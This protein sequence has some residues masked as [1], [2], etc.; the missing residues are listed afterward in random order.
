[1]QDQD[2]IPPGLC[3][4]GCGQ[5]TLLTKRAYS[6]PFPYRKGEPYRYVY[7][8]GRKNHRPEY[9]V[10]PNGC[11]WWLKALSGG[12]GQGWD[13]EQS[14]GAHRL[15]YKRLRGPIPQGMTLDHLCHTRDLSCPGGESCL[16]RRCVNP[17]HLEVVPLATNLLRGRTVVA[18]N[19][20]KTAC[21][22]GHPFT[23]ETTSISTGGRR[24]C[25]TCKQAQAKARTVAQRRNHPLPPRPV[26]THCRRKHP[27]DGANTITYA[28]R[29]LV[30]R[31][32]RAC[33]VIQRE[34]RT[35]R[36]QATV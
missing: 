9:E 22:R 34:Q 15:M 20:A 5:A 36:R 10:Q 14:T 1:M 6:K 19:A 31:A 4:C 30:K 17:D 33:R 21:L 18:V 8:H 27:F 7:G 13:G 24:V 32:C 28:Y 35:A 3:Q 12:Y 16:H 29:G 2:T 23:D 25:R 26:Q 11:W